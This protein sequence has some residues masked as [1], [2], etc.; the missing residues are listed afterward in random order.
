MPLAGE[1]NRKR[2]PPAPGAEDSDDPRRQDGRHYARAPKRR[3]VPVLRRITFDRWRN[4][5]S[6]QAAEATATTDAGL[7][8]AYAIGGSASVAS[9]EA[10]EMYF[11]IQTVL[12]PSFYW[13]GSQER[14]QRMQ[15]SSSK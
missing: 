13:E 12:M 5:I 3:S 9:T 7:P 4:T 15:Q 11:V 6:T 14:E 10:S 8:S 1:M 2:R